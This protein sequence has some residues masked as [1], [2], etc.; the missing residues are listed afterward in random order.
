MLVVPGEDR[1]DDALA[2]WSDIPEDEGRRLWRCLVAGGES[3]A[4][5]ALDH[6]AHLDRSR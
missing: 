1:W 6:M 2:A 5:T 4:A 3:N